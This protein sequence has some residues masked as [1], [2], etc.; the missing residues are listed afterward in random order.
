MFQVG[1]TFDK[2]ATNGYDLAKYLEDSL[3]TTLFIKTL[4]QC[5]IKTARGL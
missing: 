1:R 4:R 2:R 5:R 3:S